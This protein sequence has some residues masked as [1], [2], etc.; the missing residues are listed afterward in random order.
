MAGAAEAVYNGAM[1]QPCERSG[2]SK[3]HVLEGIFHEVLEVAYFTS[4]RVEDGKG[5]SSM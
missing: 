3:T 2:L 4:G 1:R 5:T